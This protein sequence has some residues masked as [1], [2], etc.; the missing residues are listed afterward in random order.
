MKQ[1]LKETTNAKSKTKELNKKVNQKV[2]NDKEKII[3]FLEGI[4]METTDNNLK[5]DI[6][7]CIEILEGKENQEISDLKNELIVL[8]EDNEKLY[9]EKCELTIENEFLTE[10]IENRKE[11]VEKEL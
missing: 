4:C 6:F 3:K 1:V 7:K 11:N 5:Y 8:C 10:M 2:L 9:K